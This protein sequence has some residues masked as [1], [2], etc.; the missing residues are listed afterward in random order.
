MTDFDFLKTF[1]DFRSKFLDLDHCSSS[2]NEINGLP[3]S[4]S[5]KSDLVLRPQNVEKLN[6]NQCVECNRRSNNE[7]PIL[8]MGGRR[9][10]W[11]PHT[12][13]AAIP[14]PV[15]NIAVTRMSKDLIRT[16]RSVE[17]DR[18]AAAGGAP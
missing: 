17:E 10:G 13:Q 11:P 3:R 12:G 8:R 4:R 6:I 18:F 1:L 16:C 9:Q 7:H 2:P 14:I 15:S 5:R